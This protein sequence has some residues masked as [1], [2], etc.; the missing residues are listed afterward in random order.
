MYSTKI[1][2]ILLYTHI[3]LHLAASPHYLVIAIVI[4][5]P[6]F[7]SSP[8]SA[9][10]SSHCLFILTEIA[11]NPVANARS[12]KCVPSVLVLGLHIEL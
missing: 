11:S 2:C 4:Y 5:W 10:I 6:L 7:Y 3:Y 8:R 9:Y 1:R 12:T